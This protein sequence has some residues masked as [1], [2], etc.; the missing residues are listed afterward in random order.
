MN[1]SLEGYRAPFCSYCG[2]DCVDCDIIKRKLTC[3]SCDNLK[4]AYGS[5]CLDECPPA[6]Y[7]DSDV[8]Q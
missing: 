5:D 7:I 8:C 6:M 4:V 1:K 2:E 3:L